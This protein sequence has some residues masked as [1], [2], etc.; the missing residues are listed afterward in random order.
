MT[1]K[2]NKKRLKRAFE[3]SMPK[4]FAGLVSSLQIV[5]LNVC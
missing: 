3:G 5:L 4:K 2:Y 1:I